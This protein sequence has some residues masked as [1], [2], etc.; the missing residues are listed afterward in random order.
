MRA[1]LLATSFALTGCIVVAPRPQRV[2]AAPVAAGVSREQAIDIAFGAARGRGLDVE[3]VHHVNHDRS[4][5]WHVDLRGRRDRAKVLV[6][7]RDG[8]IL[9]L[10]AKDR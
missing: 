5:R 10:D 2:Q 1:L 3:R 9:R 6:D 4:G 7:S 8:R